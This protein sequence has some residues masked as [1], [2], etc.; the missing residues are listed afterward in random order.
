MEALQALE[1]ACEAATF[2]RDDE[3]V[4]D[5]TYRK[6]GK[7]DS[8]N[9]LLGLDVDRSRLVDIVHAGLLAGQDETKTIKAE[10]YKLNVYG[11]SVQLP[12]GMMVGVVETLRR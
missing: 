5:E 7:M 6:A 2:G 3:A 12:R 11:Q 9:F 8:D 10:L 1:Q 4:L